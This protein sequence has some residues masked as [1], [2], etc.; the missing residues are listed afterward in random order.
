MHPAGNRKGIC[1]AVVLV[2]QELQILVAG[3][4]GPG[5]LYH[6]ERP[7]SGITIYGRDRR[8]M[9]TKMKAKQSRTPRRTKVVWELEPIAM[10][11]WQT[12][13]YRNGRLG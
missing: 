1:L 11:L 2:Q 6:Y 4:R 12:I 10:G 8:F 3:K 5:W 7:V 13:D 9:G